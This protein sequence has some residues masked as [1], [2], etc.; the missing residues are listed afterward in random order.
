MMEIEG[1]PTNPGEWCLYTTRDDTPCQSDHDC[2]LYA[3]M[4][5]MCVSMHL[6]LLLI[7][8]ER[9]KASR[10]IHLCQLINLQPER[11]EPLGAHVKTYDIPQTRFISIF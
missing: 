2:G 10:V 11:A 5:G 3:V 4:Y 8:R 1:K 9:I 6:L 7:S